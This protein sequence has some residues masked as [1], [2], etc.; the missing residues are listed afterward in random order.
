[1]AVV[2]G[3]PRLHFQ[4]LRE[5]SPS[6]TAR[7]WLAH[8]LIALACYTFEPKLL[9]HTEIATSIS[10]QSDRLVTHACSDSSGP[11]TIPELS[12]V[13]RGA[14]WRC[15][16]LVNYGG[17]LMANQVDDGVAALKRAVHADGNHGL[18]RVIL[19]YALQ[20][21]PIRA[22]SFCRY[23]ASRDVQTL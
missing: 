5:I 23:A 7:S 14:A 16:V 3:R 6:A 10:M 21:D 2:L 11:S 22:S 9:A 4:L 13:S 8:V 20:R 19:G 18:A 17:A 12:A 15:N 1:M